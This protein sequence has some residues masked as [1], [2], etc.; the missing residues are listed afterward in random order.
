MM[1]QKHPMIFKNGKAIQ[2]WH[3][4]ENALLSKARE[5]DHYQFAL[6][7]LPIQ[8]RIKMN[9]YIPGSG[10]LSLEPQSISTK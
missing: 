6:L 5:I 10:N 4:P 1:N 3:K 2:T 8:L 7:K 9:L